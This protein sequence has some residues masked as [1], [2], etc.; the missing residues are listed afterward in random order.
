MRLFVGLLFLG[1]CCQA[2]IVYDSGD[3]EY[4][5]GSFSG[6]DESSTNRRAS[7]RVKEQRKPLEKV[8]GEGRDTYNSYKSVCMVDGKPKMLN[9]FDCRNQVAVGR[10]QNA[11]NS[12]GWSN[13][14]IETFNGNNEDLQAYSAGYL[15]GTLSHDVL[16]YHLQNTYYTYCDGYKEY[17]RRLGSYL[18]KNLDYIKRKVENAPKDDVYWQTVSCKG[19]RFIASSFRFAGLSIK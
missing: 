16:E 12:T 15:E 1:L 17:C 14:E 2:R 10:W 11:I 18:R 7:G 4:D 8:N 9:M 19:G 6:E 13:L 3:S 5:F